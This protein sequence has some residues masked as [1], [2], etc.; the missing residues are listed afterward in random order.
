MVATI[1]P[2]VSLPINQT[3]WRHTSDNSYLHSH[4]RENLSLMA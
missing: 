3:K 2:E 4:R 1:F